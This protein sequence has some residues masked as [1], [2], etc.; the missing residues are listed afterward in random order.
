MTLRALQLLTPVSVNMT[1]LN[2]A[3][4]MTSFPPFEDIEIRYAHP[5]SP[6]RHQPYVV[7][8]EIYWLARR[9][10]LK[11]LEV[12]WRTISLSPPFY[13]H[14]RQNA[15]TTLSLQ[16]GRWK[17][18]IS[19]GW[20]PHNIWRRSRHCGRPIVNRGVRY[21]C[22]VQL[23]AIKRNWMRT[24]FEFHGSWSCPKLYPFLIALIK[25]FKPLS[26]SYNRLW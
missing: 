8:G 11:Q 13:P 26:K 17:L 2:T 1:A 25:S 23:A 15:N 22:Y 7:T 9:I 12:A 3:L 4:C 16:R 5:I 20:K 19:Y 14:L 18:A 24:V 10:K 6:N 21:N